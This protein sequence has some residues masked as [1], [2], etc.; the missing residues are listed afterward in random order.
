MSESRLVFIR[1]DHFRLKQRPDYDAMYKIPYD[2][3]QCSCG[4]QKVILRRMVRENRTKSCGCLS[5]E[6]AR[7]RMI[8]INELGLT[9]RPPPPNYKNRYRIQKN[10]RAGKGTKGKIRIFDENGKRKY[11]TPERLTA[12]HYGLDG[13]VHSARLRPAPWNKGRQDVETRSKA[14]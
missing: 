5:R 14:S 11:V 12:I 6:K 8:K 3:Y 1:F 2:L 4:T 10:G 13:E 9:S 7:E